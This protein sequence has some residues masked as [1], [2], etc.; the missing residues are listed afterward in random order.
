V[1][2]SVVVHHPGLGAQQGP[3]Y[4]FDGVDVVHDVRTVRLRLVPTGRGLREVVTQM[5]FSCPTQQQS[6][7]V[8]LTIETFVLSSPTS[9][10]CVT[11]PSQPHDC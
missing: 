5:G 11:S 8:S 2:D 6:S 7:T 1:N 10:R 9:A 3:L 4:V